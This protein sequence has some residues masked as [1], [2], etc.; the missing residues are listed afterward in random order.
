LVNVAIFLV[1]LPLWNAHLPGNQDFQTFVRT[2]LDINLIL[3]IF[4]MLPVYPLDGGQILWSLLWFPLG[5]ARSLMVAASIGCVAAV[6]GGLWALWVQD[7][8]LALVGVFVVYQA[9][10]GFRF[11]LSVHR[12]NTAP[13]RAGVACPHCHQ[14]PPMGPFWTCRN[15]QTKFDAFDHRTACPGCGNPHTAVACMNCG[16]KSNLAA[17]DLPAQMTM[18]AHQL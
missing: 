5:F 6:A 1:T 8:F 17:W 3:L 18:S 13:R 4:N 7:Y 11:A 14:P 2:V 9:V 15:C 16:G 10:V 12:R